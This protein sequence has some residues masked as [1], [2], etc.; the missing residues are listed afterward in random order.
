MVGVLSWSFAQAN[1]EPKGMGVKMPT[2]LGILLSLGSFIFL[3]WVTFSPI[4]YFRKILPDLV[5]EFAPGIIPLLLRLVG[6][7]QIAWF[8]ERLD[9]LAGIP[10]WLLIAIIPTTNLVVRFA[11]TLIP[12]VS[13]IS[14]LWLPISLFVGS[15]D[16]RRVMGYLQA[17]FGAIAALLLLIEMPV[18][19]SLGSYGVFP[20]RLVMVLSGA[21]MTINVWWAWIGLVM[22]AMGGLVDVSAAYYLAFQPPPDDAVS[23][24]SQTDSMSY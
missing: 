9:A 16:T 12:V 20:L 24:S 10:G 3:P 2:L 6:Q 21:K 8:L 4:S 11:L 13:G 19:H 23:F 1:Q 15:P 5:R 17:L 18:I 7:D 22:I 14:L